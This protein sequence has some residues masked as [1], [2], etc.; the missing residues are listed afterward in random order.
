M[1]TRSANGFGYFDREACPTSTDRSC[2]EVCILDYSRILSTIQYWPRRRHAEFIDNPMLRCLNRFIITTATMPCVV[3]CF[4][5]VWKSCSQSCAHCGLDP[6]AARVFISLDDSRVCIV[7]LPCS[8]SPR[9]TVLLPPFVSA[10]SLV[11]GLVFPP[12]CGVCSAVPVCMLDPW[13]SVRSISVLLGWFLQ[14]Y[15]CVRV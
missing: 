7:C 5:F 8:R 4:V 15:R 11:Y 9:Q 14:V 13:G 6:A 12:R 10:V 2:G 1:I 3:F